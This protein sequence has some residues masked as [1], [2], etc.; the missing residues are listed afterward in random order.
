MER[1]SSPAEERKSTHQ[2]PAAPHTGEGSRTAFEQM[3]REERA[4]A[5]ERG[6]RP[7]QH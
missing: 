6:E 2:K 1:E 4:R 5:E 3:K 7:S